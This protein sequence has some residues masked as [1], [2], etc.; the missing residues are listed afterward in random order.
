MYQGLKFWDIDNDNKIM[1]VH[2]MLFAKRR[3]N[4]AYHVFATMDGFNCQLKDE[5][6]A[7]DS[8]WQPWEVDEDLFECMRAYYINNTEDNVQH[9]E[10]GEGCLSDGEEEDEQG[11]DSIKFMSGCCRQFTLAC[12]GSSNGTFCGSGCCV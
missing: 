9:Y 1:T 12:S 10:L 11:G 8:Y 4:N 3:G 5:H 2:K 6:D 7:N